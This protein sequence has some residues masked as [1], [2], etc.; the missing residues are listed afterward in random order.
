VFKDPRNTVTITAL[1]LATDAKMVSTT[2]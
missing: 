1:T 2:G